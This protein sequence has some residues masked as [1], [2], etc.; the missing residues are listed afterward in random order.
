[1]DF[2]GSVKKKC[3]LKAISWDRISLF[4]KKKTMLTKKM[5]TSN[6]TLM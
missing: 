4:W 6:K 3:S 2:M 1:M 5:S